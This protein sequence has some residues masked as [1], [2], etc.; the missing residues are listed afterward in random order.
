MMSARLSSLLVAGGVVLIGLQPG[1]FGIAATAAESKLQAAVLQ[2]ATLEAGIGAEAIINLN[3]PAY[4]GTPKL[5]VLNHP[6]R[7]VLD[8]PGVTRGVLPTKQEMAGWNSPLFQKSRLAQFA[9]G[10]RSRSPG[11]CSRSPRAPRLPSAKTPDGVRMVLEPGTGS[12]P[13]QARAFPGRARLQ[14]LKPS[15]PKV[16][17]RH[18]HRSDG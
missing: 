6:N 12:D 7:V 17:P 9:I 10:S 1:A 3:I 13:G 15:L 16:T 18:D 11:S 2:G 4:A 5:Q 14:S 8:L